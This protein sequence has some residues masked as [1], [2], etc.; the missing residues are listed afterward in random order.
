MSA[1]QLLMV[2]AFIGTAAYPVCDGTE[3]CCASRF[4][5]LLNHLGCARI[6]QKNPFSQG[7]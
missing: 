6:P 7:I 2:N 3:S 1:P 4:G 5:N